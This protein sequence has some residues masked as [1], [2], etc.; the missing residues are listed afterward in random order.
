M[1]VPVPPSRDMVETQYLYKLI[2]LVLEQ[3]ALDGVRLLTEDR[4][5]SGFVKDALQYVTRPEALQT[6]VQHLYGDNVVRQSSDP[7][8]NSK[9]AMA[10]ATVIP[11]RWFGAATRKRLEVNNIMPTA[12]DR[13][14]GAESIPGMTPEVQDGICIMCGGTGKA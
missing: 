3:A 12:K 1:K 14:G 13:F 11:G 8:A 5:E 2:G 10:G 4:Q 9:A 6:V 7:V